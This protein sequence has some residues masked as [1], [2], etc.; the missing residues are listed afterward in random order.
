[1]S[2]NYFLPTVN[3]IVDVDKPLFSYW[4]ILPFVWLGGFG[5]AM[6]RIPSTLAGIGTI[7]IVFSLGRR[8][9]DRKTG[10]IAAFL[11]LGSTMFVLWSRTASAES[12]NT[13]AVWAILWAFLSY[14]GSGRFK[15]LLAVYCTA[16]LGSFFKGPVAAVT[17]FVVIFVYSVMTSVLRVKESPSG[18]TR[19]AVFL[20]ELRW[21]ASGKGA[22]AALSGFALFTLLLFVPVLLTGSWDS[23]ALMWKENVTRFVKPFDHTDP[24]T[25]YFKYA[26]LICAPWSF[27]MIASLWE[28]LRWRGS[29]SRRFLVAAGLGIFCF[30]EFSGS[31]RG[32]YI[33]PLLP[34]LAIIVGK[35]IADWTSGHRPEERV[36]RTMSPSA[37]LRVAAPA[38]ACLMALVGIA[39]LYACY[40][41]GLA[42]YM[43]P[44]A[45]AGVVAALASLRYFVI[46]R[47]SAGFALLF[48]LMLACQAWIFTQGMRAA[49]QKRTLRSFAQQAGGAIKGVD[50]EKVRLYRQG[51]ASLIFY[52][53][54]GFRMDNC[55][56]VED[57]E[58]F[59]QKH[60]DGILI[61]DLNDAGSPREA[62][63]LARM[64]TL[65]VQSTR[66]N[67]REEHF[68]ILRFKPVE[69]SER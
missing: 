63:Y 3:G 44:V 66:P 21:I 64:E 41:F 59:R 55:D 32:Y 18:G 1:M 40:T 24:P 65:V 29:A 47:A 22:G 15:S 4:A 33:L 62:E 61:V 20:S 25:V 39:L 58:R 23:A 34:C 19:L 54:A 69:K 10:V 8:L 16:A 46:G 5:E 35:V 53:N 13:F 49:E 50:H 7:L 42:S 2:G 56:T 45:V 14:S 11:L 43:Y 12:I 52:L 28:M 67:E 30:F 31:R 37:G 36:G 26:L 60:P 6:L 68:A 9:F 51:T 57:L 27:L 38:S 17:G 48:V